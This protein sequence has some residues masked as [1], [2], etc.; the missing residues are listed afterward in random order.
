MNKV[1]IV[2]ADQFN[3]IDDLLGFIN[4]KQKEEA[5]VSSIYSN[6]PKLI[7]S[8]EDKNDKKHKKEEDQFVENFRSKV[9]I[10]SVPNR[11][12]S[13]EINIWLKNMSK[14]T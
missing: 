9:V 4:N 3:N 7:I 14:L 2:S 12:I 11:Y 10:Q 5:K 1:N 8:K 13:K 6:K